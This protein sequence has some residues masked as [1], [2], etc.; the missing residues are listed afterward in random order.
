MCFYTEVRLVFHCSDPAHLERHFHLVEDAIPKLYQLSW[1][2]HHWLQLE[3]RHYFRRRH[4]T[5]QLTLKPAATGT[6]RLWWSASS[7]TQHTDSYWL[8]HQQDAT[9]FCPESANV[10]PSKL[11]RAD[12]PRCLTML[13]S[14]AATNKASG[15]LTSETGSIFLKLCTF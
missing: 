12:I 11:P 9:T 8:R 13:P 1:L 15:V 4:K 7:L 10:P 2:H 6:K 3:S 5:M 14:W